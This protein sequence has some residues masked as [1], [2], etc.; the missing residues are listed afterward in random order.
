MNFAE[1]EMSILVHRTK[2]ALPGWNGEV[3]GVEGAK[4]FLRSRIL[5][6]GL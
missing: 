6:L 5:F 4:P 3:G 2:H 1:S